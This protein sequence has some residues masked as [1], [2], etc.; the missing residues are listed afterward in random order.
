VKIIGPLLASVANNN[1][2]KFN[3]EVVNNGVSSSLYNDGVNENTKVVN[4]T[5][6]QTYSFVFSRLNGQNIFCSAETF[7]SF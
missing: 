3:F 6:N 7:Q 1:F 5:Y 4:F 2:G